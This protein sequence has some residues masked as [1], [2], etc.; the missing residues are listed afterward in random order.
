MGGQ[1]RSLG[2][3]VIRREQAELRRRASQGEKW[4][5]QSPGGGKGPGRFGEGKAGGDGWSSALEKGRGR[6]G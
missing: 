6:Q 4:Q 2:S 3:G 1:R 5:E